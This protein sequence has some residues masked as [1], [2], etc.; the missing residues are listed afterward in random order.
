MAEAIIARK[1]NVGKDFDFSSATGSASQLLSGFRMF[2]NKGQLQSGSIINRGYVSNNLYGGNSYTLQAGYYTGGRINALIPSGVKHAG[3]CIVKPS[4]SG[5]Y[6]T[7][8][9]ATGF[10]S[11]KPSVAM[12][13]ITDSYGSTITYDGVA[14]CS[15]LTNFACI[16]NGDTANLTFSFSN[17][18]VNISGDYRTRFSTRHSYYVVCYE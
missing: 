18:W 9:N 4:G 8:L 5:S 13:M 17:G 2:D 15:S 11:F 14:C 3:Y 6:S 7:K 16:N 12:A 1:I 10:G